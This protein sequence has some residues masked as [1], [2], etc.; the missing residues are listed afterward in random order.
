MR[1]ALPPRTGRHIGT[2]RSAEA[3]VVAVSLRIG[4]PPSCTRHAATGPGGNGDE[5]HPVVGDRRHQPVD[6]GG[7]SEVVGDMVGAYSNNEYFPV[8]AVNAMGLPAGQ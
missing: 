4:P 5:R 6:D 7:V 1:K 2:P 3:A 8:D